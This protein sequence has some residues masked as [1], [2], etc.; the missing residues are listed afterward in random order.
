MTNRGPITHTLMVTGS[1]NWN[2]EH[3]MRVALDAG[4]RVTDF[5]YDGSSRIHN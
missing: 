5:F 4:I 1:R 3:T 2:Y